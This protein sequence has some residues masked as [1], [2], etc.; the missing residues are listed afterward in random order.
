MQLKAKPEYVDIDAPFTPLPK[1]GHLSKK[2][3]AYAA[4]ESAIRDAYAHIWSCPDWPAVR[5]LAGDADAV[6]PPGGPDRNQDI[7]TELLYFSARDGHKIELKLYKSRLAKPGAVL[8]YRMHGGGKSNLYLH[9]SRQKSPPPWLTI[10]FHRCRPR[11][12][13]G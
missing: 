8:M 10:H 6:M 9:N 13:R 7:V 5:A 4:A 2:H 1:Q 12:T 11:T 3:P